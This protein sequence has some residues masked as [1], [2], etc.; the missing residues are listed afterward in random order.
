[1]GMKAEHP[2][3]LM[4]LASH[5]KTSRL[6]LALVLISQVGLA[7]SSRDSW[8]SMFHPQVVQQRKQQRYERWLDLWKDRECRIDDVKQYWLMTLTQPVPDSLNATYYWILKQNADLQA[9]LESTQ[10]DFE[11][12]DLADQINIMR[13]REQG[14]KF[15]ADTLERTRLERIRLRQQQQFQRE[16]IARQEAIDKQIYELRREVAD[17]RAAADAARSAA[18]A[19]RSAAQH[20]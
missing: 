2:E 12:Q 8:D 7:Q 5:I 9:A 3:V 1:M 10:Y 19:A 20:Y 18:E 13:L 6:F 16:M 14:L 15:Q 17:A 11:A 4:P